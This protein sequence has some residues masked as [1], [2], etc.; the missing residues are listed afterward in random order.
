MNVTGK[1]TLF[2]NQQNDRV[3]YSISDGSKDVNGNWT[4]KS[5]NV[6]FKGDAPL[7]RSK[8]EFSGFMT[9]Y[10]ADNGNLYETI[11]VM[12]WSYLQ[13]HKQS[14]SNYNPIQPQKS[15]FEE[16]GASIDIDPE[17]LPF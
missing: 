5:W 7:D 17:D 10:K 9:Y 6:R 3:W 13:D 12:E 11:Q 14:Q 8:I 4:N 15:P 2:R 16:Y 1:S